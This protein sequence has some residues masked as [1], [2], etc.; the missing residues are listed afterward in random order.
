VTINDTLTL[1]ASCRSCDSVNLELVLDLGAQRLSDFSEDPGYQPP[2]YP[3]R[4]V[5]CRACGLAQ[6]N[7]TVPRDLLYHDRYGFYSGVNEAI[8]NDLHD[9][10][11]TA[12]RYV[13]RPHAWLDI[14]SNDG[15]LLSFV[16]DEVYRVGVDPVAKFRDLAQPHADIILPTYFS[17]E[18][19]GI[20][21][22]DVITSVSVFYDLDDPAGFVEGVR[23]VLHPDGVWLIQQNDLAA[24]LT[25]TAFDNLCHEHLTYWSV[26]ALS[27]LLEQHGLEILDVDWRPVNGGCHRVVVGHVGRRSPAPVVGVALRGERLL[28]EDGVWREF[29]QGA[30]EAIM[31]LC[32]LVVEELAAGAVI[33]LYGASTR[34]AVIWQAAGLGP[35]SIRQ[36]VE[37]NPD[38][39]GRWY[40]P[41][42]VPIVSEQQMREDPPDLLLVGPWW[43]RD[44]FIERERR[45]LA[46]GRRMVFPLPSLE[47]VGG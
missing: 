23:R 4:L 26:T 9:V 17:P 19:F 46:G 25:E 33:D 39:V 8:R 20:T 35:A 45:F 11:K 7:H 5:R 37:R 10:V 22:F 43:H 28:A 42:G 31:G 16:G 30:R 13:H 32:D 3:L 34:G 21:R 36:A 15:T 14:A 24:M 47:V 44:L 38:K 29:A 41:V 27:G 18:L 6:L 12:R 1:R 2:E 40:S